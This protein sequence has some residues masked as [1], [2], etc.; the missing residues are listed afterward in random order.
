MD[1]YERKPEDN[2]YRCETSGN[3]RILHWTVF[4][5]YKSWFLKLLVV[6]HQGVVSCSNSGCSVLMNCLKCCFVHTQFSQISESVRLS[7]G[8]SGK[9]SCRLW[10]VS[11]NFGECTGKFYNLLEL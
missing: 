1:L 3:M 11:R 4:F 7:T 8:A 6:T 2:S 10:N 9:C 5:L